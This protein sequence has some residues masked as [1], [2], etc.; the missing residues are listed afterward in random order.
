M[1]AK[2]ASS[3]S[4]RKNYFAGLKQQQQ[5]RQQHQQS[6]PS[7]VTEIDD[8][9]SASSRAAV[10]VID[11]TWGELLSF[12]EP[13]LVS[14]AKQAATR[15]RPNYDN[16]KR[17]AAKKTIRK[18]NM[19]PGIKL[20]ARFRWCSC[21][22]LLLVEAVRLTGAASLRQQL[23]GV[24]LDRVQR[25]LASSCSCGA[26]CFAQFANAGGEV[27]RFIKAFW[28]LEKLQQDMFAHTLVHYCWQHIACFRI[29]SRFRILFS[30]SLGP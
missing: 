1:A 16:R 7:S 18:K 2:S 10:E 9:A 14:P 23:N 19:R 20:S 28:E 27:E 5:Q 13:L 12:K 26:N 29:R 15:I 21:N 8:E 25:V 3:S 6:Q 11:F 30:T 22:L 4:T 24:S 17:A